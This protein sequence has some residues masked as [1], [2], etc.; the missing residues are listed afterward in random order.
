[1]GLSASAGL[2]TKVFYALLLKKKR[3][4]FSLN[5]GTWQGGSE[6]NPS[7]KALSSPRLGC[8][9]RSWT[10]P[11]SLQWFCHAFINQHWYFFSILGFH[12][13]HFAAPACLLP[14]GAASVLLPSLLRKSQA[15]PSPSS[16]WHCHGSAALLLPARKDEITGTKYIPL[17]M[18][19]MLWQTLKWLYFL[20]FVNSLWQ[21]ISLTA[22]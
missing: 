15:L 3:L 17:S 9:N 13:A 10:L 1:M 4:I 8:D 7:R 19:G 22:L 18:P 5:P 21:V 12:L 14:C 2:F 20:C 11:K 16:P 6:L